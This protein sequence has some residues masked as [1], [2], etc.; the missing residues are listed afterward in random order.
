MDR[1]IAD[2]VRG[3]NN[4]RGAE[5]V[6]ARPALSDSTI[7]EYR[8]KERLYR[9]QEEKRIDMALRAGVTELVIEH[10]DCSDLDDVFTCT[11]QIIDY[12]KNGPTHTKA[13]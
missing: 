1:G 9:E 5:G 4:L 12:I 10:W 13:E 3:Y 11:E 8:E 7:E 2:A 6:S